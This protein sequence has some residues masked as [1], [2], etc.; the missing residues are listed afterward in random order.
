MKKIWN[1]CLEIW[2]I[3]TS[4]VSTKCTKNWRLWV[5]LRLDIE[6]YWIKALNITNTHVYVV[7]LNTLRWLKNVSEI[8]LLYQDFD[9]QDE[10]H[11]GPAGKMIWIFK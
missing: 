8:S 7:N 4:Y 5:N 2:V 11:Q 10:Q 3:Y 9:F 1:P 6:N